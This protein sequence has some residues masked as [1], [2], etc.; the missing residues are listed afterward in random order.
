MSTEEVKKDNLPPRYAGFLAGVFSGVMKNAVGHP[1]DSV[2]VRLQTSDGRFKGPLDCTLKTLRNEGVK[3]LYKGFTPPLVGWVLM[4]SV[5]LG[6]LHV[7]K[8]FVKENMYPDEKKLPLL[9]HCIAGLGSGLTVSF[10]AAPIEQLKARL[11]I[12]YDAKSKIYTGPIDC[13]MKLVKHDGLRT[14]YKGL[15][16]TMIFR[17]NFIVW[18]GSYEIIT[19]WFKENTKMNNA[20]INFWA[21]GLSATCFWITAYPADVVKNVIMID[22]VENPRFKKYSDAVKYVYNER[23]GLRGFT[24]GFVPS[25]LRSFP[26]NAAALACFEAVMRL[27][28]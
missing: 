25:I 23:G 26:A 2:K 5:M 11:Q 27:F 14:L 15:I 16:P 1:F 28:N 3:G 6:S 17:T 13:F 22:N 7:Y 18:W 10:V 20:A 24:R 12:Q 21:G 8:R 4:D 19:N 9:G